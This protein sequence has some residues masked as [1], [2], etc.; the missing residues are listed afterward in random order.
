VRFRDAVF[1]PPVDA[2]RLRGDVLRFRTE[3]RVEAVRLREN[4]L[5][6][7]AELARA[8]GAELPRL[9]ATRVGRLLCA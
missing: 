9:A 2:V 8:P 4:V 5:R 6:V 1:R 7:R 3:P